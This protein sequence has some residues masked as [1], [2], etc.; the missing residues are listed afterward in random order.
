MKKL[1]TIRIIAGEWRGRKLSVL[2]KEGLRPTTDR[3]RETLF[4]WLAPEIQS[5][6]CL[7][8]FAGTGAL[9]L[10]SLSR[11]A[12]HVTFVEREREVCN[13]LKANLAQLSAQQRSVCIENDAIR[14]L[15]SYAVLTRTDALPSD[16]QGKFNVVFVDPPYAANIVE[17]VLSQIDASG[18]LA[19]DALIYVETSAQS[20]T[21]QTPPN[22]IEHRAKI[23]GAARYALYRV[24]S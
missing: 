11:G 23:A 22:W 10:E 5:A 8:L 21:P 6:R 9:G 4:N 12:A 19:T 15:D 17:T 24:A 14:Y 1:Q 20:A 18:M 2:N 16:V 13:A 7:D 3:V